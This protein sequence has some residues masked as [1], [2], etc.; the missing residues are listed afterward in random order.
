ML[1]T[2][3]VVL[4]CVAGVS[5]PLLCCATATPVKATAATKAATA[6]VSGIGLRVICAVL[7]RCPSGS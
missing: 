7:M 5:D 1:Y 3:Y 4:V 6:A 2:G